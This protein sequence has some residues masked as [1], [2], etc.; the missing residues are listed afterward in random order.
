MT[1]SSLHGH[2]ALVTGGSRGIGAA[3]VKMLADA[4]AAIA[5]N[6]RERS[7][8]AET[9][10][11][12]ITAAGGRAV[13]IA[14]DVS[15]AAA[16]ATLLERAKSE[17]GPV[18]ILVNNAGIAIVR[19]VD[20]LTEEDFDRTITVNLK[21]AFLC[22]Q[23]VLPMMRTRKWGRIVNISSG[24]ARGAGSIGPHYNASK[25]AMEGLTRGYA[26]RLVKE[27]ITVN[28]VA[29]SL[30]ET[31]MMKGQSELVSRIPMGRFGTAEEVAQAVM[32]LVNN[33]YMTGQ[34]IAMSG[35]MAFN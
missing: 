30:I 3:I 25:A 1:T 16:V 13:A 7:A 2:V 15:E 18:D 22:T 11:K 5:I 33:P 12:G 6:Y 32:L 26:A 10:A 29:P 9:L 14:G 17:L 31:D 28:A 8:A 20:D 19:G 21:S 34:T 23:A 27:G 35:G 24:A 4:G